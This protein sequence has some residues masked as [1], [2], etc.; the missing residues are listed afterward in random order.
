M[1]VVAL[2]VGTIVGAAAV[3]IAKSIGHT[4]AEATPEDA[5]DLEHA[6]T[7]THVPARAAAS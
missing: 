5:V 1:F 7:P 6:H 3:T 2:I 4:D